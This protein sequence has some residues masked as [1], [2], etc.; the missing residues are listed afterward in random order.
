MMSLR[1]SQLCFQGI[2]MVRFPCVVEILYDF[3]FVCIPAGALE[4]FGSSVTFLAG[5]SYVIS[6]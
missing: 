2:H 4:P 5:E 1:S 3:L 6:D